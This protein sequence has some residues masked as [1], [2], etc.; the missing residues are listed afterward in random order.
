[1][2]IIKNNGVF[3]SGPFEVSVTMGMQIVKDSSL[4]R[5]NLDINGS[6]RAIKSVDDAQDL[7]Y[8]VAYWLAD[9]DSFNYPDFTNGSLLDLDSL[10]DEKGLT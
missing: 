3:L 5:A 2:K 7:A 10:I 4:P 6:D 1:M 8:Q 9:S